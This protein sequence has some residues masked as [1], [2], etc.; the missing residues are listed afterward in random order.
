MAQTPKLEQLTE[1]LRPEVVKAFHIT[2]L[3]ADDKSD[4]V[5]VYFLKDG[6]MQL[7]SYFDYIDFKPG[8]VHVL[9]QLLNQFYGAYET[10]R[11]TPELRN[12]FK[13]LMKYLWKEE[14][15]HYE[16]EDKPEGHIFEC[17]VNI[18][19]WLNDMDEAEK[20]FGFDGQK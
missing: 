16:E 10:G 13:M 4:H 20:G 7:D 17:L 14:E 3:P 15:K 11:V 2:L 1:N 9:R 12:D 6:T 19:H 8:H 18:K 5:N